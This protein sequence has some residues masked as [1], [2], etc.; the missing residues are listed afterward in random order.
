MGEK[1][2]QAMLADEWG[3][4]NEREDRHGGIVTMGRTRV[5]EDT[6]C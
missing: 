2:G 6:A 3:Q 5:M 4:T 1:R